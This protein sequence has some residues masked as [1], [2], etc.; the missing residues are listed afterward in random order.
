[1]PA[2]R[3]L[4]SPP[5]TPTCSLASLYF[6][7]VAGPG[8]G[9]AFSTPATGVTPLASGALV[10]AGT[11]APAESVGAASATGAVAA[12]SSGAGLVPVDGAFGVPLF[13]AAEE[14]ELSFDV[15]GA[16]APEPPWLLVEGLVVVERL[17]VGLLADW[18]FFDGPLAE[19][20][21]L[22]DGVF[23]AG[24]VAAGPVVVEVVLVEPVGAVVVGAV[25]VGALVGA[26]VAVAV[27][28][29]VAAFCWS[30]Q[31]W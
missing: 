23:A 3:V 6:F 1:M 13:A 28:V 10:P 9:V 14:D 29:G 2:M 5:A 31:V 22:L 20:E 4:G 19:E 26:G 12:A 27:G 21:R 16:A 25:V 15:L 8:A 11:A 17:V 24:L 18:F 7:A 30:S